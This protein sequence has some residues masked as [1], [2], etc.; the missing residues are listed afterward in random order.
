MP[1]LASEIDRWRL[2]A[3]RC[4]NCKMFVKYRATTGAT[5]LIC[6]LKMDGRKVDDA[7]CKHHKRRKR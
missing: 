3:K 7:P 2:R 5:A 6:W 1:D 4:G